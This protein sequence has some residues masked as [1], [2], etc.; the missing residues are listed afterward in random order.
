[1]SGP[2]SLYQLAP[3]LLPVCRSGGHRAPLR[4]YCQRDGVKIGAFL[5]QGW[6]AISCQLSAIPALKLS[7]G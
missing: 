1:M 5:R 7:P 2:A 3:S 6:S 4:A